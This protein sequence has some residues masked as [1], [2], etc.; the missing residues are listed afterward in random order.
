M[1]HLKERVSLGAE[2]KRAVG[3][4]EVVVLEDL[5]SVLRCPVHRRSLQV[6]LGVNLHRRRAINAAI[7]FSQGNASEDYGS[8]DRKTKHSSVH[9]A[10]GGTLLQECRGGPAFSRITGAEGDYLLG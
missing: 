10:S 1:E 4:P 6:V 3:L 9:E 7:V 2:A 5:L 8:N